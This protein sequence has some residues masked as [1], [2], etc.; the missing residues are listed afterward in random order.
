MMPVEYTPP[1]PGVM[2][3]GDIR[4]EARITFEGNFYNKHGKEC[5]EATENGEAHRRCADCTIRD[6]DV[7][8]IKGEPISECLIGGVINK[9]PGIERLKLWGF[10]GL[11][12]VSKLTEEE[13]CEVKI[14]WLIAEEFK[15]YRL[16]KGG[17]GK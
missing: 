14:N 5:I 3:N 1:V 17:G 16:G 2:V 4:L 12:D 10:V 15:G 11:Y 7:R 8:L 13:V 9:G 6:S